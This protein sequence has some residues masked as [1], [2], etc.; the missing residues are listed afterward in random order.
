M[1]SNTSTT[2]NFC[3][4][5]LATTD[6]DAAKQFYTSLFG[7]TS[8]DTPAGPD[9]IYTIFKLGEKD[10]AALY[11]MN[12]E[13]QSHGVPPNWMTYVSVASADDSAKKA[14]QLGG[15][16]FMAPFD[17]MDAGRMALIQDPTGAM[18]ATW[19]ARKYI[20]AEVTGEPNSFCWGELVT[21]DPET[22]GTFYKGLFDWTTKGMDIGPEAY[23][24]FVNNDTPVGGMMKITE[25]MAGVPP[26]WGVYFAVNDCDATVEKAVGLGGSI[27]MPP[28]DIPTVG[29]FAVIKDPQGAV[30]SVIKL[31][32]RP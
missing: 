12:K 19:E 7:W 20:G 31:Q 1:S 9:M 8:A 11:P 16:I 30:F 5:E 13:Q 27:V 4:F 24:E 25:Q 22:A 2:G 18:I 15:K 32:P 3:W 29:R 23:T 6:S 17:V 14:E 21:T 10:A 26:H 28:T